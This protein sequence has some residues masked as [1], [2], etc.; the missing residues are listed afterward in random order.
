MGSE[1]YRGWP[2]Y[3]ALV[4]PDSGLVVELVI[5]HHYP[6]IQHFT[7]KAF[8]ESEFWFAVIKSGLRSV[9]LFC[10]GL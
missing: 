1:F 6:L 5:Y 7:V 3:E 4:S 8:A 2:N 9:R 10:W